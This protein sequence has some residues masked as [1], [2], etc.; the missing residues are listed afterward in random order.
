MTL[1]ALRASRLNKV[2]ES[3]GSERLSRLLAKSPCRLAAIR[4]ATVRQ[5]R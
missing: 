5:L 4:K 3:A 2:G 1:G